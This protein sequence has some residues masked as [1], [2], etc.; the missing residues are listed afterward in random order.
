MNKWIALIGILVA[1]VVVA[2]SARKIHCHF[3][4]AIPVQ[5][6]SSIRRCI[7]PPSVHRELYEGVR[8]V[9]EALEARRIPFWPVA[10]TLLG[11]AR[12]AG[13]IPWD[14]DADIGVWEEDFDRAVDAITKHSKVNRMMYEAGGIVPKT[15]RFGISTARTFQVSYPGL[16]GCIDIISM[17]WNPDSH[18]VEYT[19]AIMR[20]LFPREYFTKGEFFPLRQQT[21]PFGNMML[22]CVARPIDAL[23]RMFPQWLTTAV[24]HP[25]DAKYPGNWTKFFMRKKKARMDEVRNAMATMPRRPYHHHVQTT[26]HPSE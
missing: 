24:I 3:A 18:I 9:S 4:S 22:P 8:R 2:F 21:L 7:H 17:R 5:S 26:M 25:K 6:L 20:W 15:T 19:S 1:I 11:G 12:H 10:G 14:K 23:N 16:R 13:I